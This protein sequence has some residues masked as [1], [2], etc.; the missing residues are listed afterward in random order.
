MGGQEKC[1]VA[2]VGPRMGEGNSDPKG[3]L[4]FSCL[5]GKHFQKMSQK[6]LFS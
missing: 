5:T 3:R 1:G 6:R 2:F 4:T